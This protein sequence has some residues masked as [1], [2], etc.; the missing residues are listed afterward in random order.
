MLQAAT[1]ALFRFNGYSYYSNVT[2]EATDQPIGYWYRPYPDSTQKPLLIIHGVGSVLSLIWL[3]TTLAS[4][5]KTR[6]IFVLDLKHISMRLPRPTRFPT[7]AETTSQINA[8]LDRHLPPSTKAIFFAHSL[9]SALTVWVLKFSPETIAGLVL[10]DPISLLLQHSDVAYNFIYRV[11]QAAA[12]TFFEWIA[13][14]QG[15]AL[16]LSRNFHWFDNV[17][18]MIFHDE[19]STSF[20]PAKLPVVVFLS[21]GDCIV[22]TT[23]IQKFMGKTGGVDVRV[24]PGLDHGGFLFNKYWLD[25]V[26][27]TLLEMDSKFDCRPPTEV[28]ENQA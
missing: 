4:R 18:P 5:A 12:E 10:V 23:R 7:P 27:R 21:E 28:T 25:T 9:G 3:V 2:P 11:S 19:G 24:M 20:F 14:E 22:P 13:R 17:F 8:I 26:L 6:P 1:S 15:I 16:S